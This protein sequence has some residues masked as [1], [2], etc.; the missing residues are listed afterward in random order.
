MRRLSKLFLLIVIIASASACDVIG[1]MFEITDL[2]THDEKE[3]IEQGIMV[4][5]S[6]YCGLCH[7]LQ[8]AN[9]AGTFGPSHNEAGVLAEQYINLASYT[10]TASSAQEY[11]RESILDPTIFYTPGY[12]ATNHHM[13]AFTNLSDDEIEALVFLLTKQGRD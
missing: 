10:G 13:P 4:Y 9:T 1:D 11:I 2:E 3:R 8:L 5:R 7:T 6:N 12:E